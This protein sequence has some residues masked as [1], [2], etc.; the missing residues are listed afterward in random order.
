[1]EMFDQDLLWIALFQKMRIF[2]YRLSK[3]RCKIE[4]TFG[5]LASQDGE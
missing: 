1:M 4:C 3:A 5:L 2:N